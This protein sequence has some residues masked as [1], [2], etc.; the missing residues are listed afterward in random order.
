MGK[1][2][3]TYEPPMHGGMQLPERSG[4]KASWGWCGHT[5]ACSAGHRL[6]LVGYWLGLGHVLGGVLPR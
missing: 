5:L 6:T 3:N 1:I 4:D 2:G